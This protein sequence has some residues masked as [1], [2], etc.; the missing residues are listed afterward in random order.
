MFDDCEQVKPLT[1]KQEQILQGAMRIFL[2]FGFANTSMDRI[3]AEAGVSKQTIYSHFQD[4][5]GLFSA[6]IERVT[7]RRLQQDLS[8][9]P[10]DGEPAQVLRRFAEAF[11]RKM[12]DPEYIAVLRLV[13][14][15]S[16]RFP[17]LAQLFTQTV[18]QYGCNLISRYLASCPDLNIADPDATARIF[19]GSLVSFVITQE[20]LLGKQVLP[21][22]GDRLIHTLIECIVKPALTATCHQE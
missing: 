4:K 14:G 5:N 21:L 12:D 10:L 11:L 8:R 6:L 9:T 13:M 7:I 3:A 18:V 19:L 16:G 22:E 1:Q 17:E 2:R 20:M 15:E